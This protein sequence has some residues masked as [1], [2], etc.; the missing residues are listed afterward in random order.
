MRI[1]C[2]SSIEELKNKIKTMKSQD[3]EGISRLRKVSLAFYNYWNIN[4]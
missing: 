3:T 2:A 4:T 1:L